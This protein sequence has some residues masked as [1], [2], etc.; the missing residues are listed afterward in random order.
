MIFNRAGHK[1][2]LSSFDIVKISKS[3]KMRS[4]LFEPNFKSN[5]LQEKIFKMEYLF[6]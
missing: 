5:D 4:S 3:N 6:M 1:L 2:I